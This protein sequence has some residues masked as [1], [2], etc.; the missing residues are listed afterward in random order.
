MAYGSRGETNKITQEEAIEEVRKHTSKKS[1]V[2]DLIINSTFYGKDYDK[3][4]QARGME[5]SYYCRAFN[6]TA[7]GVTP[8]KNP[9]KNGCKL[10]F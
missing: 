8:Q 10:L 3:H 1:E 7:Y 5:M 4:E 6:I 9:I 2:I